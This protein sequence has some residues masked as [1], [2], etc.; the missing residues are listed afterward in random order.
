MLI[1]PLEELEEPALGWTS[2]NNTNEM[3]PSALIGV[4]VAGGGR[5]QEAPPE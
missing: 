2:W 5:N 3:P 4:W 1:K